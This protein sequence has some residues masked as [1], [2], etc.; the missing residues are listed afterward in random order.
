MY[1]TSL[2][3]TF[4]LFGTDPTPKAEPAESIFIG[5]LRPLTGK[6]RNLDESA[7][8]LAIDKLERANAVQHDALFQLP[9]AT[10][11]GQVI[12]GVD[13]LGRYSGLLKSIRES[14]HSD[15]YPEMVRTLIERD[16]HQLISQ[17]ILAQAYMNSLNKEQRVA[18][19]E[20]LDQLFGSEVEKLQKELRVES[21]RELIAA[22]AE[23]G[24][25]LSQIR[26]FFRRERLAMEHTA[27]LFKANEKGVD[28]Q[29]RKDRL[30]VQIAELVSQADVRTAFAWKPAEDKRDVVPANPE[31]K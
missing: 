13:V 10:V 6:P 28:A 18:M 15:R 26:S 24:A 8:D 2:L 11:N 4:V 25:T 30:I 1:V 16:L 23:R 20:H 29:E 22:L 3:V 31:A 19:E 14:S 5:S 9:I 21:E 17:T 27:M 7:A 12:T